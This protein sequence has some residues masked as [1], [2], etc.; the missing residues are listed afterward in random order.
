MN[1]TDTPS[2]RGP[3]AWAALALCTSSLCFSLW[4]TLRQT[5]PDGVF[6]R[7]GIV[8]L[9]IATTAGV[10]ANLQA[11]ASRIKAWLLVIVWVC[12]AASCVGL[13]L[14]AH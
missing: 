2:S 12:L 10:T 14:R 7:Y 8:F 1:N 13:Y 6:A 3:I 9:G 11:P 4:V 5:T